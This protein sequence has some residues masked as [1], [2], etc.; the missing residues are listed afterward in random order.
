MRVLFINPP[1]RSEI[2]GCNPPIIKSERGFDPP[3]GIL[4]VAGYLKKHSNHEIKIIDAQVD[5]LNYD[6]L[7]ERIKNFAPEMI[8]ITAMTFTLL[9]VI[10]TVEVA[11]EV[12]PETK[13]TLGGPHV[14]IYPEET[15]NLK[16]V[17]YVVVGEGE[18]TF[19]SLLKNLNDNEA[20]KKISGLVF[21]EN[22]QIINTG[23]KSYCADLDQLPFPPREMI[24]YKKYFSL[25]A[26]E[27]PTTTM[28]TS[29]G[30]PFRCSFCDRPTMGKIFRKRSFKN[31]V[32]EM[33]ECLKLDIKEI[34][35]YDDTFTVDRKRVIDVCEEILRRKL[36]FS[37][38]IRARVDTIDET[39]LLLLKKSGCK[40]IHYGVESG[41]EKI[42][43]V[44]NKNITLKKVEEVFKLTRKM[45]IETLAYFMIGSPTETREDILES[46]RF[47][48]KL[49]P[50]F[51]QITLLT[52]FP[53]TQL[54][55]QALEEK[56]F[57][58]DYW[59]EFAKNPQPGFKTKY[60]TK[61]LSNDELQDLLIYAYK[62]FYVRP[63]YII[64][65]LFRIRSFSEL[66]RKIKAGLKVVKMKNGESGFWQRLRNEIKYATAKAWT[67]SDVG[68]HWDETTDYDDINERTY[69]YFRRF[70]DADSLFNLPEKKHTLDICSRTGNGSLYFWKKGKI[71]KVLCAD[72]TQKMQKICADNLVKNNV[73]FSTQI[74]SEYP[75]P[76]K[77]N[78]FETILS[79]ETIEHLPNPEIFVNELNRVL[80]SGGYLVLTM[81]NIL[82]EPIHWLA[83]IFNIHHSEGPHRFLRHAKVKKILLKNNFKIIKQKTFVL[84]PFG[85]KFLTKLGEKLE[86]I[87]PDFIVNV[88]GLRRIYICQ[89]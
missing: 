73:D 26:K 78:Q 31:V 52:P 28:F 83:A 16:N 69:S 85:P 60:W 3:L 57:E 68:K 47:A 88:F 37:W 59:R 15:I 66:T 50:D 70:T 43:K 2:V 19:C 87:L 45:G 33:E 29:R 79:F 51:T 58:N 13:I 46:I 77:N 24:P 36:K 54:Y 48:K 62:Q 8:G 11:K 5:R 74:I 61:E 17:D 56:V 86:K 30:C 64:N 65:R 38:D 35:I 18:E 76:F 1:A 6:E 10:K 89:K 84:V 44:L 41:T 71:S 53:A 7:K 67:F 25:L 72:V 63:S 4:Y 12:C 49:N 34:F 21:K 20:L 23:V 75:L 82:W 42:L 80:Q 32:D 27:E 39:M 14:H 40:R 22:G 55:K 81:P 9:D